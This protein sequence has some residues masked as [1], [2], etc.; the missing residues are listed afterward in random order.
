MDLKP[1]HELARFA[2]ETRYEDLPQ[3]AR[4]SAR[5]LLLDAVACALAGDLGDETLRYT[6]FA[7]SAGGPGNSTVIGSSETLSPLGA[8]LLNGYLIT[9][10]TICD[11]YVPA[12]VHITPEV[13]PP[14]LAIAAR[15]RARGRDLLDAIAIGAEVAVRV[16]NGID[17]SVAGPRG[18]H[19][20]G[21]VG[22]FGSAAAVGRLRKLS[23]L[24]MRNAFGLAGSQAAGTWA[25][26][27]TPTVKFHQSRGAASGLASALLAETGFEASEEILS[28]PNGGMFTAFSDG[29]KP[30]AITDRL[31]ERFEFE[32]ISLRLWPGGTPLQCALTGVFDLLAGHVIGL[33]DVKRVRVH[34]APGVHDAHARF[35]D[36]QG[37]FEALLSY[38]FVVGSALR[39]GRLWLDSLETGKIDDP[40]LRYFMINRFE[41]L[42]DAGLSPDQARVEI[43]ARQTL[44]T[45]VDAAKGTPGNPA[46]IQ[47]LKDKYDRCVGGRLNEADAAELFDMLEN[48]EKVDDIGRLFEL[49][50]SGRPRTP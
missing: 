39:D 29:G 16:A 22:P 33:D 36:P 8:T 12:H 28:H 40:K 44:S 41:L 45:T 15:D 24:K 6:S 43:E 18:W 1:T 9:A 20:P 42:P 34:V 26:W 27:G 46:T 2:A 13:V 21:I 38:N 11:T 17:Y 32:K 10:I 23:P 19:F 37:K 7:R 50:R 47:D 14:S 30:D 3:S 4:F 48:I 49:L 35:V 5:N 31:G 25:S